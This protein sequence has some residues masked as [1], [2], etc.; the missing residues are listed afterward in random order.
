MSPGTGLGESDISALKGE[1]IGLDEIVDGIRK[2]FVMIAVTVS[3][4]KSEPTRQV[5]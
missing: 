5:A 4:H 2:M 1:G 3:P